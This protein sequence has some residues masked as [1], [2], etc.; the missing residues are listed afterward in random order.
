MGLI[1]VDVEGLAAAGA[2]IGMGDAE[3]VSEY[4][5]MEIRDPVSVE[6]IGV[7]L[8][9]FPVTFDQVFTVS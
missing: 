5:G 3:A 1:N 4:L 7:V 8:V 9:K 2:S 6:M